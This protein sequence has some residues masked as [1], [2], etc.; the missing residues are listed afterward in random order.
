MG[1][2]QNTTRLINTLLLCW[3]FFPSLGA[4]SVQQEN[5]KL[6]TKFFENIKNEPNA[7]KAFLYKMPKGGN[8]HYH[9]EGSS[10]A[11]N[12]VQYAKEGSFCISEDYSASPGPCSDNQKPVDKIEANPARYEPLIN[13]WSVREFKLD[14]I[15]PATKFF[16][17]FSK[18]R[19]VISQNVV[20]VVNE[21]RQRATV[22]NLGYIEIM[23]KGSKSKVFDIAKN[24][25][26]DGNMSAYRKS[27]LEGGLNELV[28]KF[29]NQFT[30]YFQD[31]Q[32]TLACDSQTPKPGCEV[33]IKFIYEVSR[34]TTPENIFAQMVT[35][36]EVVKMNPL[37]VGIN[38]VQ[39]EHFMHSIK[40][41]TLHME[42]LKFLQEIYPE[43]NV[44]LHAGELTK[45]LVTPHEVSYHITEAV[46]I[47]NAKRI[48]HGVSIAYEKDA[49]E[50]INTMRDKEVAV[51]INL[52]SNE[53]ILGVKGANHPL[54]Y[55]VNNKV[56]VVIATDDEGI[57]RTTLSHEFFVTVRD[58]DFSYEQLKTFARNSI[59]YSFL[60]GEGLWTD[61]SYQS[62]RSPCENELP[63]KTLSAQCQRFLSENEKAQQAWSLEEQFAE[64][65]AYIV[66]QYNNK[67]D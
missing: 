23:F 33:N 4:A 7:L 44:A 54:P 9:L 21:I 30:E 19:P 24:F 17:V 11:E 55:Y 10:Y 43:V 48:G 45:K 25:P 26:W 20:N 13:A 8:L 35:A 60:P 41:Y 37:I 15:S 59:R 12:L 34:N 53:F 14:P 2:C 58:Y 66:K 51:E 52:S 16:N 47:A 67:V 64:F 22:D 27:L 38:L 57:L 50:L 61:A 40:D 46:N 1:M 29:S 42:M 3:A 63:N 62:M 32:K 65:E 5:A 6:T 49:M 18:Y 36:F 31:S 28:S 56:P 39:P